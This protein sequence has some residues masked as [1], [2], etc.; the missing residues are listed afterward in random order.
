MFIEFLKYYGIDVGAL[1]KLVTITTINVPDLNQYYVV[2]I[3]DKFV[4]SGTFQKYENFPP[5]PFIGNYDTLNDF[6]N[7]LKDH[8]LSLG[9]SVTFTNKVAEMIYD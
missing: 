1:G 9:F 5:H 3:N 7:L 6:I 8:L 2:C 4:H